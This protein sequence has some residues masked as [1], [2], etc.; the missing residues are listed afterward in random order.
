MNTCKL[1][2]ICLSNVELLKEHFPYLN[3]GADN[4]VTIPVESMDRFVRKYLELSDTN[5]HMER[6]RLYRQEGVRPD[7]RD[8]AD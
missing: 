1:A 8:L 7:E 3:V 2:G 4:T 5:E 6:L